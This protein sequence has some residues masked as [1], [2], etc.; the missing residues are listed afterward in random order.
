MVYSGWYGTV[1]LP[2]RQQP[3]VRVAFPLPN[4]SVTV[5]LRPEVADGDRL[6]LVSPLEPFGGD[7]MYLIVRPD[8]GQS[9]WVR[10]VPIDERFELWVDAEGVLRT[11][12][13]LRLWSVP[14]IDLHY[15]LDR[16]SS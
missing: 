11:S 15:R 2:G 9:A 10:R 14:V 5:F 1:V 16:L 3:S 12:H 8:A 13:R 4:G 7:G 6:R